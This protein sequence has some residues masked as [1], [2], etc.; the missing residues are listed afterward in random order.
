MNW[1]NGIVREAVL[2]SSGAAVVFVL[3]LVF[4]KVMAFLYA[5]TLGYLLWHL[6]QLYKLRA[7]LRG[8][9]T[10]TPSGT[11]PAGF[12]GIWRE[13][14]DGIEERL[15]ESNAQSARRSRH[16]LNRVVKQFN[17]SMSGLTDAL[18]LLDQNDEIHW[19][20]ATATE[21]LG[22]GRNDDR[23]KRI[24]HLIRYPEFTGRLRTKED[25]QQP[26][27]AP[28]P[29]NPDIWLT[30]L[31]VSAGENRRLVQARDSTRLHQLEQVRRDFVANVSHELRTPLTVIKG[32][33]E[34]L[35]DRGDAQALS[36]Y[37][38]LP[39][40]HQQTER[41]EKLVEDLLLLSR[42]ELGQEQPG[43]ECICVAD[44]LE[45]IR[46]EALALSAGSGHRMEID[47]RSRLGIMGN[48]R[49]LHSAF[50]NLVFN[51]VRYTTAGGK[52]TV[53]WST[54]DGGGRLLVRD[55][56]IGIEP[57]HLPR[58]T[59]RF[60]RIDTGRSRETG[61]TGLGL[62][63]V[64]HVLTQHDAELSI[65]SVPGKGSDFTCYFPPVRLFED[66]NRK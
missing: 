8:A 54:G 34:T 56:G 52:I 58:I 29:V 42:L 1:R 15:R 18:V 41:M 6:F 63:I 55:T 37:P 33:V 66:T 23:G 36:W 38:V 27:E 65:E 44:M 19:W 53:R 28:S 2:V 17:K 30:I 26:L 59:E 7:W 25:W 46:E 22:I 10:I 5:A 64:K 35:L 62:T 47:I 3:G 16:K 14:F 40:I 57:R 20:N 39:R 43:E 45:T 61:G 11:D 9:G 4:E 32:Y 31:V 21:L 48:P 50:S 24:G 49:Q 12:V 13:V 60:Y 51:A